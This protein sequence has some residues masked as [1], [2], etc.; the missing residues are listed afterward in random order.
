MERK[1]KSTIALHKETIERLG[2]FGQFNDS[3]EDVVIRLMDRAAD[4]QT[5]GEQ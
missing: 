4:L 2:Q 5:A 3:Y 1:D